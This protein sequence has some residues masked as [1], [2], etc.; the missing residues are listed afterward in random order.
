MAQPKDFG[1][2]SEEQMVRDSARKFLK[3]NA[4][5]EKLRAMVARDHKTAYESEVQPAPFDARLWQ[6]IVDL[7]WTALAVPEEAGGVGMKMIAVA[8]LAEEIGRAAL[9][10]PAH[11]D[12]DRD[13]G[14]AGSGARS[15][16]A[17]GAREDRGRHRGDARVGDGRRRMG[18]ER[19]RRAGATGGRRRHVERH[20]RIRPGRAQGGLLRR[21]RALD[22]RHRA[23]RRS[24]RRAR[25]A[26]S[27]PTRSSTSRATRRGSRSTTS[28]SARRRSSRRRRA[29]TIVLETAT[30][31]RS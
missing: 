26:R 24:E 11:R 3:E 16:C 10:S 31:R 5:I 27:S 25:R 14:S 1:F 6:Q 28:A 9:P 20:G 17:R 21:R 15:R 2:G 18:A 23:L 4:G 30:A 19:E 8:A 29:A 7:G 13:G 22:R 12:A